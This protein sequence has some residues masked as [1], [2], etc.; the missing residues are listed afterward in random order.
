MRKFHYGAIAFGILLLGFLVWKT[1]LDALEREIVQLG[2]GLIPFTL[3]EG[4]V[5]LF[6][7]IGFRY[8]L[9]PGLRATP[10]PKLFGIFL[11]GHAVNYFTPTATI[12]GEVVKAVLLTSNGNSGGER[13]GTDAATG[14]IIGKLS[15]A[16]TQFAY[17]FIGSIVILSK[18]HLPSAG[19]KLMIASSALV[20]AGIVGFLLVQK[21]GKLGVILRWLTGRNIGGALLRRAAG[22]ISE[23]D[24]ALADF[25]RDRP[26]DLFLSMFWHAVGMSFSIVKAW[27]FLYLLSDGDIAMAAGV[28]FL[29]TWLDIITFPIPLEI[30]VQ[31]SI[32]VIVFTA[33]GFS[34]AMGLTYG[35]ALRIEEIFW[36]IAGFAAYALL[37]RS[38]RSGKDV[39]AAETVNDP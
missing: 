29:G 3:I 18:I 37:A 13:N 27:Y 26:A 7:T 33:L 25:Y 9:S 28:W 19:F 1:G 10:F 11:A 39:L 38:N 14:V 5:F 24:R 15:F 12:G 2:F 4:V 8:C 34:M 17:A 21:Y 22:F 20:G 36:A 31:E 23:V 35:L 16:L 30:G 32:R 6:H